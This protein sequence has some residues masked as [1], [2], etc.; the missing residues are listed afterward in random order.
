M[1]YPIEVIRRFPTREFVVRRL[2]AADPDFRSL[3][4][5]YSVA[6]SALERW[7]TDEAK[8]DY[9]RHAVR[10]LEEE[11]LGYVD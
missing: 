9:Y 8:A 2:F 3:C 6:T 1:A 4:E 5:D 7:K 11:I 10:E